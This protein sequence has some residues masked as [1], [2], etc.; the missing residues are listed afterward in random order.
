M[1]SPA[2]ALAAAIAALEAQRPVLGDAVVDAAL[3]PLRQQWQALQATTPEPPAAALTAPAQTRKRVSVLF[4]DVV[5]ST[6][7][8]Q[9]LDPEEVHEIMDGALLRF[10]ALVQQQGGKVL[11]Y[12]GDSMLCAFGADVAAEDDA[13]RAVRAGLAVIAA[14]RREAAEVERRHGH[15]GFDVRVGVHTGPVLLGGGVDAEGSIRGMTVNVA[16]RMEQSA[17][18]GTLRISQDTYR[19]VTGLFECE[20]QPPITVKGRDEPILTHL[21][22]GPSPKAFRPRTRGVEGV[23]TPML[24]RDAPWQQLL[25]AHARALAGGGPVRV[26][27]LAEAGMGK[28]RLLAEY[29]TWL[30]AQPE[31]W[32]AWRAR[33]VPHS[34]VQPYGLL[35]ELLAPACGVQESH[36]AAEAAA[37][38][39]AAA[40]RALAGAGDADGADGADGAAVTMAAPAAESHEAA[41]H[42]LGHLL[43]LAFEHSPHVRHLLD[44][45][46]QRRHRAFLAARDLI[47]AL[48]APALPLLLLEDLHWAD[49]G[50]LEFVQQWSRTGAATAAARGLALGLARPA[51]LQRRPGWHDAVEPPDVLVLEPLPDATLRELAQR[52]LAPLEPVPGPLLDLLVQRAEGH[53]FYLEELVKMLFDDGAITVVEPGADGAASGPRWRLVPE[54]LV[55]TRVPGTLAGIVQARLDS[56]PPVERAALQ[57]ASVLGLVFW[58][59]AVAALDARAPQALPPL[60]GRGL[61]R[62]T[63][64]VDSGAMQAY[65]FAHQVLHQVTYDSVLLRLRRELHERAARW[66]AGLD[67]ARAGDYL[68]LAAHHFEQAEQP[69]LAAEYHLRAAEHALPRF[70][71]G[72]AVA[73]AD[74]VLRLVPDSAHEPR[75]RALLVR[76]RAHRLQ[77]RKAESAADVQALLALAEAAGRDD[78]RAVAALRDAVRRQAAGEVAPAL[79]QAERALALAQAT[80][81]ARER[82]AATIACASALRRLGRPAEAERVLRD[83][84]PHTQREGGRRA[85]VEMRSELA[86][87]L[88]DQARLVDAVQAYQACAPAAHAIGD[89]NTECA[90]RINLGDCLQRLGD[91][92]GAS[93]ALQAALALID[94]AGL[95]HYRAVTLLNLASARLMA[96]DAPAAEALARDAQAQAQAAGDAVAGAYAVMA[97]AHAR[98]AQGDAVGASER[99]AEAAGA[100]AAQQLAHLA[101]EPQAGAA[102]ALARLGLHAEARTA[103]DATWAAVQARPALDGLEQPV[104]LRAMLAE[105]LE[106]VGD[107]RAATAWQQARDALAAAL[108]A[109]P[110]GPWRERLAQA[111]PWHRALLGEGRRAD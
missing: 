78:W 100:L 31:P 18:P 58:D 40:M 4:M 33:A 17:P 76:Q 54:R 28:T 104:R 90:V 23:D 8:A 32:R 2:D 102:L 41:V 92:E 52:L 19:Q 55:A 84:L 49:D 16:A 62:R 25:R 86:N 67:T 27:L 47:A 106:R 80:G 63:G 110:E 39:E 15:R 22:R 10:T 97:Q 50:S 87:L 7:L 11:Q 51:L 29:E 101:L 83:G 68:A 21:V 95:Q 107:P 48:S 69:V 103:A 35:R 77:G 71:H 1:S 89:R 36:G 26:S 44:D 75:W 82:D 24:G 73:A 61:I 3:A 43:G 59:A 108:Q 20:P 85:E 93:L 34:A 72:A 57:E 94:E 96:L 66:L 99:Y 64:P 12:A 56:L 14:A 45:E 109:V 13:E 6:T 37:Q 79:E 70:A 88:A 9:H 30:L 46:R 91:A 65:A 42:V 105:A 53:P 98:L 111:V 81:L 60:S 74:A 5:G 38:F